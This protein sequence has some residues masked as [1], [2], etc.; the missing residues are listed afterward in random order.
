MKNLQKFTIALVLLFSVSLFAQRSTFFDGTYKMEYGDQTMKIIHEG[1]SAYKAVFTGGCN[2]Q[3]LEGSAEYGDLEIPLAGGGGRDMII[4][5]S[6]GNKLNVSVTNHNIMRNS[7]NGYS[8]EGLYRKQN[9]YSNNNHYSGYN[10]NYSHKKYNSDNF[11]NSYH[12]RDSRAYSSH[13]D[14]HDLMKI[15]APLAYDKLRE[16]GFHLVKKGDKYKVWYNE[17]TN[18]CIKTVSINKHIHDVLKSTHC[19]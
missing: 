6:Q 2:A 3:T 8:I 14:V 18:Q 9:S 12:T 1:G 10:E 13:A 11:N 16:R 17:E 7:C 5:R 19:N 15:S 4:I